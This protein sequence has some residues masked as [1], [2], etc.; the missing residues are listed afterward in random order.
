[1]D[2]C[3]PPV[4]AGACAPDDPVFHRPKGSP[5][6]QSASW[7]A[8][9]AVDEYANVDVDWY[10]EKFGKAEGER[11]FF[12]QHRP[13]D[14]RVVRHNML[15]IGG[16]SNIWQY[17]IGNGTTTSGQALTYLNGSN[18]HLCVGDSSTAEAQD[19]TDL[20]ATTNKVRQLVD[21]GYPS[22]ATGTTGQ[23]ITGATNASPIVV[24]CTN[25]Y[26]EGDFVFIQG[27][28]GNTAA[29]GVWRVTS[30]SGT[31][32]TLEGSTGNGSYTSGGVASKSR[33]LTLQATFSPSTA[34][35]AWNEWGI[36]NAS[37]GQRLFNRKV[38]SLG[39]K[40]SAGS[41]TLRAG[42]GLGDRA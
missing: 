38:A 31:G 22:H 30:V 34:N 9:V 36:A 37:S 27:V 23:A 21:S 33:V 18:A 14:S 20:Q 32:F 28:G 17:A 13:T 41:W 12:A 42:V 5:S 40:T 4:F 8:I 25:S 26:S 39:T 1:M 19:Q 35:F 11:R 6:A 3:Y 29:N 10:R 16:S 2:L 7:N 15:M 24:T